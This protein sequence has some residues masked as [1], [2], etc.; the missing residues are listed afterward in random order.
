M[1]SRGLLD[2]AA[3]TFPLPDRDPIALHGMVSLRERVIESLKPKLYANCRRGGLEIMVALGLSKPNGPKLIE[4][5][6]RL[7][8]LT[9]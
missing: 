2:A 8:P 7:P 3:I 4:R 6:Q 5:R 9:A 1:A